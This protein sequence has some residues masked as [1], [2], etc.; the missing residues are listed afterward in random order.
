MVRLSLAA[1]LLR[2]LFGGG[3]V[4]LASVLS[5]KLGGS[6]G[7]IFAAFPAVYLAALVAIRLDHTGSD[8]VA[9]SISLSQGALIGMGI[10]ILCA[11]AVG[12]LC[13]KRGWKRGLS[14]SIGGW[15]A[16]SLGVSYLLFS[17]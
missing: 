15:F 14:L 2:F 9:R 11:A 4:V 10:N 12:Y 6:V 13:A 16:V 3:A 17:I 8:L 1:M 5:K 7:G